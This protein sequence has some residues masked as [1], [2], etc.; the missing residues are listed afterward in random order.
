MKYL[1]DATMDYSDRHRFFEDGKKHSPDCPC[2]NPQSKRHG[3]VCYIPNGGVYVHES[4]LARFDW[5]R[6][7]YLATCPGTKEQWWDNKAF[8]LP[9]GADLFYRALRISKCRPWCVH[10]GTDYDHSWC[11]PEAGQFMDGS[12]I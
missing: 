4:A 7:K 3:E 9:D 8:I 12:G 6:Q 1:D 5:E 2:G 11:Y 10:H